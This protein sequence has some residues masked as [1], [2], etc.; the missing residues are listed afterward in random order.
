MVRRQMRRPFSAGI[1]AV[2]MVAM[3][4]GLPASTDSSVP[5]GVQDQFAGAWS[6]VSLEEEGADGK[7]HQADCT[8]MLVFTGD[9]HMSVQVMYR[10]PKA[11]PVQYSLGGYEGSFGRYEVNDARTFTFYVEG[12]LVRTL[13][14]T[15]LRRVYEFEGKQLIVKSA[16]PSEHWKVVWQHNQERLCQFKRT[17]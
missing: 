10:D 14:G 17:H 8:G 7:I 15:K 1:L 16:N 11:G 5:P 13:I 4:A 3:A 2:A 6:L 12:A 9:G